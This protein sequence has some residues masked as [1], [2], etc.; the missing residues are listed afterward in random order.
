MA[1]FHKDLYVIISIEALFTEIHCTC[2]VY[3]CPLQTP[4]TSNFIFYNGGKGVVSVTN[5]SYL[6]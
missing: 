6:V 1:E 2:Y 3:H 5:F 4:G